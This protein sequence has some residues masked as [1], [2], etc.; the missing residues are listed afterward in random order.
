LLTQYAKN[1][2]YMLANP[3]DA[4]SLC[5]HCAYDQ[6]S[7]QISDGSAFDPPARIQVGHVPAGKIDRQSQIGICQAEPV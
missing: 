7:I 4:I 5:A 2:K 6:K 3:L 1:E